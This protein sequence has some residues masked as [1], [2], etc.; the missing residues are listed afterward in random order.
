VQVAYKVGAINE[1][2]GT[3]GTAHYVEHM[4]YRATEH[5]RN[6]D[7][8]GYIDRIGGR[9]TGG[10]SRDGTT[11][12]ETVPSWALESAL[13][14]TA[15]RMGRTLFDSLEFE[16]ERNNVV[17]EANGFSRSDPATALRDA[18]M[19]ASFELHPYRYSST[20]WSQDNLAITR[21]DAYE[22]Y[23][24]Y[25][26]PNNAVLTVVGD[27]TTDEARRLVTRHFG[28][29]ARAPQ[30]GAVAV[31][32]PPQR[33]EKRLMLRAPVPRAQIDIAY[34]APPASHRDYPVLV[35]LD[36]MLNRRLHLSL[37]DAGRADL[38]ST[39]AATPY[40][41]VYRLTASAATAADAER[42]RRDSRRD[43]AVGGRGNCAR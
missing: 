22:F 35:A 20:T 12:G 30:S 15:E 29:L 28:P 24:R 32:E 25:Y 33:A 2:P 36:R 6:E 40:P 19:L 23:K 21:A 34:R 26:G 42:R 38:V 7:S 11:Y 41:F 8:Y 43:P 16:R 17:T 3:T 4:V 27:V 14:T 13:R 10:T 39:H 1:L 5:I 37:P 9:Y 18:V 31:V